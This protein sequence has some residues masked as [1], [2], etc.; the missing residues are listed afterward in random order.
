MF[1]LEKGEFKGVKTTYERS[2]LIPKNEKYIKLFETPAP[3]YYS[4]KRIDW[5]NSYPTLIKNKL[6]ELGGVKGTDA[7]F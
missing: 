7:F 3:T 2:L 1:P 4:G 6:L 5:N